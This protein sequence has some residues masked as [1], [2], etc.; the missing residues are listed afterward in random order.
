MSRRK[1]PRAFTSAVKDFV[2]DPGEIVYDQDAETIRVGDGST[3][4][5]R[6]LLDPLPDLAS[7]APNKGAALVGVR[8]F[9]DAPSDT[10]SE[11]TNLIAKTVS[12]RDHG[13]TQDDGT[14]AQQAFFSA[15]AQAAPAQI[16]STPAFSAMPQAPT[17]EVWVPDGLY[18]LTDDVDSDGKNIIWRCDEG[19]RF[20]V[21]SASFLLG[22]V[23]RRGRASSGLPFGYLDAPTGDSVMVGEGSSDNSPLV[24]GFTN[25]N[26]ISTYKT[27]DI[28]A[29]YTD[30]TSTPLL[31]SSAATFT[32]TTCVLAS[33]APVKKLRVGMVIQ[34]THATWYR[35]QITDWTPDGLTI[36][37]TGWYADGST[38]AATPSDA[39]SPSIWI[40]PF[41]KVWAQNTNVFLLSGSYAYQAA[42]HE[43]GVWN[44]KVT[45]A[46]AEDEAGQTWGNDVVNLGP[47]RCAIGHQTRGDFWEG[48][49]ATGTVVGFSSSAFARYGYA[50][51]SVGF[52]HASEATVA[53]R[54]TTAAGATQFEVQGGQVRTQTISAYA[55]V[56]AA[57]DAAAAAGGVEVGGFYKTGSNVKVRI[58]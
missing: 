14:T 28:V 17:G 15:A 34:T 44:D 30:A 39:G 3:P 18:H 21:G 4:G 19:A 42:A 48:F 49:R 32:A 46:A 47:R 10:Q 54:Q 13:A 8:G 45:P 12:V 25:P 56:E 35:G 53:F 40:N 26:Q 41:H 11:I 37:V 20:T 6:L 33:P 16:T 24:S 52:L 2:L 5:G 51:P 43:I 27:I 55:L 9:G 38:T 22:K 58:S 57:D 1:L 7:T 50:V 29:R 31:H 36:T 23:V